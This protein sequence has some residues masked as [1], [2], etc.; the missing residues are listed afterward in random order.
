MDEPRTRHREQ[1]RL[2]ELVDRDLDRVYRFLLSMT[3]DAEMAKDLTQETFLRLQRASGT[4]ESASQSESRSDSGLPSIPYVFAT[5]RNTALSRLRRKG[6]E[7]RTL[8]HRPSEDI[9]SAAQRDRHSDPS[10]RLEQSELRGALH[11]AFQLLPEKLRSTF[12]LSE[13]EGL[14]Y[15]EIGELLDCS[16]GTVA[17]RK[18]NAVRQLRRALEEA[19]HAV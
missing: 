8:E 16:S 17:S 14:S 18:H 9:E 5:A 4:S 3:G 2:K 13:I 1:A 19:G 15:A 11:A 12:I 10:H 6:L 7:D